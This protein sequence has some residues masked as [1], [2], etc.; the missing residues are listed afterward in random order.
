MQ[1]GKIKMAAQLPRA[2]KYCGQAK[3]LKEQADDISVKLN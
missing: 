2:S 1:L 3:A